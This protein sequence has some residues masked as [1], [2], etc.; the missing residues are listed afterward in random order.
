LDASID[1]MSHLPSDLPS[2]ILA[3]QL[4]A[5]VNK[6]PG[7]FANTALPSAYAEDA[8]DA[9]LSMA[10]KDSVIPKIKAAKAVNN[11]SPEPFVHENTGPQGTLWSAVRDLGQGKVAE[12]LLDSSYISKLNQMGPV[13]SAV[14]NAGRGAVMTAGDERRS[15]K[16]KKEPIRILI[17]GG[18]GLPWEDWMDDPIP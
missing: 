5:A 17:E 7:N 11:R 2:G 6:S 14:T 8:A 10:G 13:Q 4:D 12:K 3:R 16:K 1:A 18:N 15:K 9:A